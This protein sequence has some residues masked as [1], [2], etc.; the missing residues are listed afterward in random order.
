MQHSGLSKGYSWSKVPELSTVVERFN[1][2]KNVFNTGCL[3]EKGDPLLVESL[4]F[5][6]DVLLFGEEEQVRVG[7]D[8]PPLRLVLGSQGESGLPLAFGSAGS[9]PP[10]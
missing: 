3:S 8:G 4:W 2:F 7:R 1:E 9:W 5:F 10:H 6:L